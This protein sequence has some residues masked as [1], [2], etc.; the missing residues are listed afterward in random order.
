MLLRKNITLHT[1]RGAALVEY[2][3]LVGLIAVVAITA[4]TTLGD[5]VD[6]I[7]TSASAAL[8]FDEAPAPVIEEPTL[9]S[10]LFTPGDRGSWAAEYGYSRASIDRDAG[11]RLS[12][13]NDAYEIVTIY[14]QGFDSQMR[15]YLAGDLTAVDFTGISLT[16]SNGPRAYD[17][18]QADNFTKAYFTDDN[19]TFWLWAGNTAPFVVGEDVSCTIR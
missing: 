19:A 13:S 5:K 9:S 3:M 10:I 6:G 1:T 18:A 11:T 14:S 16:C 7:F 12:Q 15:L 2:G 17:L 8:V 4:V